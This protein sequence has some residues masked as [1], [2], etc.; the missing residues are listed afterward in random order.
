MTQAARDHVR[1]YPRPG[2]PGVRIAEIGYDADT[3][4]PRHWHEEA[5]V[6]L[7]LTGAL[8]E[9]VG[10]RKEVAAALSV[11]VKPACT[12]HANRYGR[13]GAHTFAVQL[14]REFLDSVGRDDVSLAHWQWV[15]GGPLAVHMLSLLHAIRAGEA[16]DA[17]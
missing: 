4:Q 2:V 3:A 17:E 13:D 9:A 8:E 10:R 14:Q 16:D 6:T 11:V 1:S 7:V 12:D 15:H 5:N